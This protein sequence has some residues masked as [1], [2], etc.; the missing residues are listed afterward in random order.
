YVRE[1]ADARVDAVGQQA[2]ARVGGVGDV[3]RLVVPRAEQPLADAQV[4]HGGSY[5]DDLADLPVAEVADRP[6]PAGGG[7]VEEQARGLVEAAV[8]EGVRP[9]VLRELRA[10]AHAGVERADAHL[11]WPQRRPGELLERQRARRRQDQGAARRPGD[12][13]PPRR[14]P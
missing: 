5:L 14:A 6:L 1:D 11:V 12:R 9:A 8:H 4:A 3:V 10:G 7:G 13:L 2:L